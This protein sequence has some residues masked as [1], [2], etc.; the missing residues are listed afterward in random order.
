MS[1]SKDLGYILERLAEPP[2]SVQVDRGLGDAEFSEIEARYAIVF[3]PDL[4]ALLA[5]GLPIGNGFVD[6]RNGDESKIRERLAWP[7]E[8]ALFVLNLWKRP[9]RLPRERSA[10]ALR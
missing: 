5:I 4:R 10:Q 6:W 1:V 9:S 3:P 2:F 8:S 7:L